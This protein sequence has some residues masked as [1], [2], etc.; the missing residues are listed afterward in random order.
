VKPKKVPPTEVGLTSFVHFADFPITKTTATHRKG[1]CYM[2]KIKKTVKPKRLTIQELEA[3]I[4]AL[5]WRNEREPDFV[6]A[7]YQAWPRKER[8]LDA[9]LAWKEAQPSLAQGQI[10]LR[11]AEVYGKG[12]WAEEDGRYCPQLGNHIRNKGWLDGAPEKRPYT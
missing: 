3:A 7:L 6:E 10:L 11:Q 1:T 2:N 12:K 9:I 8:K 5:P 4:E